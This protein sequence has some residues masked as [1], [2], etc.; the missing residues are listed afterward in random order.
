MPGKSGIVKESFP[1]TPETHQTKS[2]ISRSQSRKS[3]FRAFNKKVKNGEKR[4]AKFERNS[5]LYR[6]LFQ[7]VSYDG[8]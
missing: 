4:E 6:L 1:P 2:H 7:I 5:A 8:V 3:P